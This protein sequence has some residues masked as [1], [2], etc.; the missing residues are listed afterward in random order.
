MYAHFE[1]KNTVINA[2]FQ[3]L[4]KLKYHI[5]FLCFDYTPLT[6]KCIDNT[7]QIKVYKFFRYINFFSNSIITAFAL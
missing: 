5:L 6:F 2:N 3:S 7:V 4:F 1:L